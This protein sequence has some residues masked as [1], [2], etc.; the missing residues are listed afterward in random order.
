MING[1]MIVTNKKKPRAELEDYVLQTMAMNF[2]Q[3]WC[4][5]VFW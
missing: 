4:Y 5:E 3:A 2:A 1:I